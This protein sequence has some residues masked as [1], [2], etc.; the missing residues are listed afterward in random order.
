MKINSNDSN[1]I[2]KTFEPG[3]HIIMH[4]VSSHYTSNG[5]IVEESS[6]ESRGCRQLIVD[7]EATRGYS[8]ILPATVAYRDCTYPNGNKGHV[9]ITNCCF[10]NTVTVIAEG[11]RIVRP[12]DPTKTDEY[13]PSFG[14]PVQK[15]IERFK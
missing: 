12:E 5:G 9:R 15:A 10:V 6:L 7:E 13:F 1:K 11:L 2:T 3:K 8:L 14:K 4:E